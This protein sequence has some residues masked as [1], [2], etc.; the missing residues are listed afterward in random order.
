M[1]KKCNRRELAGSLY[2]W[3]NERIIR[4]AQETIRSRKGVAHPTKRTRTIMQDGSA[5]QVRPV[6][7]TVLFTVLITFEPPGDFETSR[8]GCPVL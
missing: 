2:V 1:E 5:R 7:F 8:F 4:S 3:R 6:L